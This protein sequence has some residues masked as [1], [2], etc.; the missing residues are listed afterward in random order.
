MFLEAFIEAWNKLRAIQLYFLSFFLR[1]RLWLGIF[2]SFCIRIL[3]NRSM[4]LEFPILKFDSWLLIKLVNG[5]YLPQ[6]NEIESNQSISSIAFSYYHLYWDFIRR[7][8]LTF[9]SS[10][11]C[12]DSFSESDMWIKSINWQKEKRWARERKYFFPSNKWNAFFGRNNLRIECS[13]KI[14]ENNWKHLLENGD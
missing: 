2:L 5:L 7:N 13:Q 11:R 6:E 1:K 3:L 10:F 14:S 8:N 4:F 9:S 12:N